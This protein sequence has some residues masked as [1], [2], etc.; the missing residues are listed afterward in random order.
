MKRIFTL[1]LILITSVIFLSSCS[2]YDRD[3]YVDE[4]YWLRQDVGEV[5][6][7]DNYCN[8]FVVE[9]NYGYS[10]IRSSGIAPFE[11]TLLYGN[12]SRTGY[13]EFYDRYSRRFYRGTQVE[14][15]LSYNTAQYLIDSYCY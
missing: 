13:M 10:I 1:G 5:V 8:Y 7:S 14:Y 2:K 15:W 9:T 4:S 11:G 12:F 3:Y 6:Y